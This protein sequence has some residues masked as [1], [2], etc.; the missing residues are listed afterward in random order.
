MIQDSKLKKE[1]IA[2]RVAMELHDGD[3]VN[4]GIGIPTLVANY[5][6]SGVEIFLQSENGILGMGPAPRPGFEHPQLI[7][8]GGM[9]VTFLPGAAAFD[10][11]MSF[12]LIRGGHV[13]ATVLGA[14]Q[15]DEEGHL[16]NWMIPGKLVPGMGGAMD[17][18]TGAKKVIVAM[19][20]VNKNGTSKIVKKCS[21]PLTSIR[22]VNLIVT[23][24]VVIEATENGLIL[25]EVAPETTVEEVIEATEAK[26]TILDKVVQ[27]P[28]SL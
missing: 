28:I 17:L 22:R 21:L 3:I 20:H 1:V 8:A 10:S 13:D 9:P 15:V 16:A 4:L 18:V 23:D 27:M 25:K 7:N 6:P 11:A 24:M 12:G 14:L 19:Q 5:L 2:K 26:L